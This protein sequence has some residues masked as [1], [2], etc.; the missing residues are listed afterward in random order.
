MPRITKISQQKNKNRVN[1]YLDGYFG[2]ELDLE[3]FIRLGIK[4]NQEL[5]ENEIDKIKNKAEYAKNFEMLLNF[6][7]LRPRSYKEIRE[8]FFRKKIDEHMHTKLIKK[9]EK[10]DL[11]DDK[12]FALWWVQQRRAFRPKSKKALVSELVKKGID[13][14]IIKQTLEEESVDEASLARRELKKKETKWKK[15]EDAFERKQKQMAYLARKGYAWDV[16]KK[17]VEKKKG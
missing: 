8:W 7:M 13:K 5:N 3:N 15:Y 1:V 12:R 9:L 17:V 2:F 4:L 14:N 11:L 16:V 6:A 10:L